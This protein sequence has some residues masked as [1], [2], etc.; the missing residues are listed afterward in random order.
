MFRKLK[1]AA[2]MYLAKCS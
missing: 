2:H 1:S